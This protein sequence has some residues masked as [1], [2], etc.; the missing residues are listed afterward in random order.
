MEK[1]KLDPAVE[2]QQTEEE[3][4]GLFIQPC[5][6]CTVTTV[7]ELPSLSSSLYLQLLST[8]PFFPYILLYPSSFPACPGDS[9]WHWQK[10]LSRLPLN[11]GRDVYH[12]SVIPLS[13]F[14]NG[15]KYNACA[16]ACPG[17]YFKV[18]R[19]RARKPASLLPLASPLDEHL[20]KSGI[21]VWQYTSV[22][23]LISM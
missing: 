9:S 14:Y 4:P 6:W 16:S 5:L 12:G 1:Q 11:A 19:L 22:S 23:R 13:P 21:W 15:L 10:D 7:I 20:A 2:G 17:L 18:W 3:C 8:P